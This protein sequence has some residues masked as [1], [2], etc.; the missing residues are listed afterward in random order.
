MSKDPTQKKQE[1]KPF[2][3]LLKETKL[4]YMAILIVTV[5]TLVF[6]WLALQFPNATQEIMAGN[7]SSEITR[8]LILVLVA[9]AFVTAIRMYVTAWAKA[10]T[11]LRFRQSMIRKTLRLPMPYYDKYMTN[12]L[13]S[14][15]TNDTT[16]LSEFVSSGIPY[17]PSAIYTLVTTMVLLFGYNWRLVV[18][19]AILI[20]VILLITILEGRIQFKWNRRIQ[21]R[22]AELTSYLAEALANVPLIKVFV[23]EKHEDEKGHENIEELYKAKRSY[24]IAVGGIYIMTNMEGVL[25]TI[26]TVVGGAYLVSQNYI[27]ISIWIAFYL[28]SNNLIGAVTQL[29]EYWERIK[30]VQGAAIRMAEIMSEKDEADHGTKA[31]PA[32][33]Q[34]ICFDHVSFRYDKDLILKDVSFVVP[35]G[36]MTALVGRSGAGKSTVFGLMERFYLPESGKIT[37]GEDV[38]ITELPLRDWR[39]HIGYV[40]QES[41]LFGG[42]IR[43]NLSYG[44]EGKLS[45]E[46]MLEA[47]KS[48]D[49]YD[50]IMSCEKGLD[51]QVGERG[52]KLSAGQRQRISIANIMLKNPEILLLDEA[53]S[54]LDADA[55]ANV[56]TALK[57]LMEGRTTIMVTHDISSAERADQI[58]MLE[59]GMV[60]GCGSKD[61]M[62]QNCQPYQTLK[63]ILDT[64]APAAV[65]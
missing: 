7:I 34:D 49:I 32:G 63:K 18:F 19:E 58:I 26:I 33:A 5:V 40:S 8:T 62:R 10:K 38:D 64:A 6:S 42:T 41:I 35:K 13:I 22:I 53:T 60:A 51:T 12:S 15:T 47:C 27:D 17:I 48:A 23:K 3:T 9:Q 30:T 29:F 56:E 4:P 46:Q 36:K 11:T 59:D 43:E 57:H 37:L 54:N 24:V 25:H 45:D 16:T 50:F 61:E 1:W 52:S 44:I 20:P 55:T 21:S 65:Q 14:R 28:Y 31:I 2:I 39:R